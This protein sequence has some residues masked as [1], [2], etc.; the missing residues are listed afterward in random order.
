MKEKVINKEEL[1]KYRGKKILEIINDNE[2]FVAL[3]DGEPKDLTYVIKG[4]EKEIK[5]LDFE[6]PLGKETFWHTSS[7]IM[8]QAVKELFP[9]A[10]LT[11]GPPIENGFHYDFY[12]GDKTFSP[13]DL[14]K[15][16]K[17]AK[18]IIKKDLKVE[19]LEL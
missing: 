16:E 19:R 2:F 7:H 12:M 10:K 15:I 9:K 13:E 17:K 11:I 8:A 5:L 6:H 14:E 1:E 18:E 3:V 4:T